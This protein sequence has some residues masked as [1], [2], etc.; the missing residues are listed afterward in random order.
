MAWA[1]QCTNHLQH[2]GR[3]AVA[4]CR[5]HVV[6]RDSSAFKVDRVYIAF[7]SVF[8]SRLKQ[9]ADEQVLGD[10]TL[11]SSKC[12]RLGRTSLPPNMS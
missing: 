11:I 4:T 5:V 12:L 9:L 7:I 2:I 3:S 10:F 1:Q 6:R 8:F